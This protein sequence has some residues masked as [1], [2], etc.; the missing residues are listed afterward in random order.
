MLKLPNYENIS[1]CPACKCNSDSLRKSRSFLG[2]HKI[3]CKKCG[4]QFEYELS[5]GYRWAYWILGGISLCIFLFVAI[6][7]FWILFLIG[8]IV[9]LIKDSRLSKINKAVPP[10][11]TAAPAV[12]SYKNNSVLT[13]TIPMY[14][15]PL[16]IVERVS[17]S[18]VESNILNI[19]MENLEDWAYEKVGE[20]LESN[21]PD[22]AL[23]TKAFAQAEG[24]D[25]QTRVL[26][27][28]MRVSK[29]I[30]SETERYESEQSV[31]KQFEA[32]RMK[33]ANKSQLEVEKIAIEKKTQE[34]LEL[35]A[36]L[37]FK[38]QAFY[39]KS[40]EDIKNLA[41][42]TEGKD[43]LNN[44]S[45]GYIDKVFSAVE[46][47]PLLLAVSSSNGNKGLHW[48]VITNHLNIVALLISKGASPLAI[49]GDG[50]SPLSLAKSKGL[51]D[52]VEV[53]EKNLV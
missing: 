39:G 3:E 45:C 17:K 46:Q 14:Q 6:N 21:T 41:E 24:D 16:Q 13:S 19:N 33:S 20:E 26:Y 43:F 8:A 48:A 30:A 9:A 34:H 28:K 12:K 40:A 37:S 29:L 10:A 51:K 18:D 53:L 11:V 2:F 22:K 15:P 5:S 25:K 23:W 38:E 49:N 52:M 44:C 35:L 7:F 47:N 4:A 1:E 36:R 50:K 27:I 31:Q 42:S 32:E